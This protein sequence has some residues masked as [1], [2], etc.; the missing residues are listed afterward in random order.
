MAV[1]TVLS[2]NSLKQKGLG[3]LSW[4]TSAVVSKYLALLT[5]GSLDSQRCRLLGFITETQLI[6]SLDAE[7]VGFSCGQT[8]NHKPE[9]TQ[10]F[11][12]H[13]LISSQR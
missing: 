3:Q 6:D 12:A 10:T 8:T 1:R 4:L 13:C 2:F 9:E 7:H 11:K 5:K